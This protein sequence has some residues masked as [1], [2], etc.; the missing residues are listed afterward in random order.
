MDIDFTS[1]TTTEEKTRLRCANADMRALLKRHRVEIR[2]YPDD[3][4]RFECIEYDE[5]VRPTKPELKVV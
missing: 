1:E 3:T 2:R 5:P 4:W